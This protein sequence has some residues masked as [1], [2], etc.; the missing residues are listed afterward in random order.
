MTETT[1]FFLFSFLAFLFTISVHESAHALVADRCG[2]PT[3]RLA[4]RISLNPL[5]HMELF[6]TVILPLMTAISGSV[7]FGWAKP[8]P[9]DVGKLRRPRRDDIL[10]SA[11]GPASNLVTALAAVMVLL[12]IR[13]SSSEG[14]RVVERL[15]STGSA[16]VEGSVLNPVA[17]LLHRLLVVSLV[18]GI[19]NLF[20][21]PPLDGS[22]I[23]HQLLPLQARAWYRS[24]SR[25]GFLI[26]L[27]ALWYT[28]VSRWTFDPAMRLFNS[29]LRM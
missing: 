15:A 3:A 18:L 17:W 11:A 10:V 21:V 1:L 22:H 5:R 26:L 19:F 2:D 14:A 4:G 7:L 24:T 23:V 12:M 9:V 6:G 20:P 8:T 16:G 28:P 25:Y 29:L 27:L 13:L